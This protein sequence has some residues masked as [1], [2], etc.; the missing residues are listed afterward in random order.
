[1]AQPESI[2]EEAKGILLK[3][4]EQ[5]AEP[6]LSQ[7]SHL[8]KKHI[9]AQTALKRIQNLVEKNEL[10]RSIKVKVN[11]S[12]CKE[13]EVV[14]GPRFQQLKNHFEQEAFKMLREARIQEAERTRIE[15][16]KFI[17]EGQSKLISKCK[18]L[19][20][21][22]R[23]TPSQEQLR[24]LLMKWRAR[25]CEIEL[26][27]I[28]KEKKEE[29]KEQKRQKEVLQKMEDSTTAS[30]ESN[31]KSLIQQAL[32]KELSKNKKNLPKNGRREEKKPKRKTQRRNPKSSTPRK[33]LR[34]RFQRNQKVKKGSEKNTQPRKKGR[35]VRSSTRA[36]HSGRKSTFPKGKSARP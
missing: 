32:R 34:P 20:S 30:N 5:F 22:T 29:E 6:V 26:S 9:K 12:V 14:F 18:E 31:I 27:T 7:Y 24:S 16:D 19:C 8:F 3:Y 11:L 13:E 25:I 33:V 36:P 4:F 35:G 10:P 23:F 28:L 1:M 17:Q 15:K 2:P 21:Q